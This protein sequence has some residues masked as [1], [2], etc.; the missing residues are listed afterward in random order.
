MPPLIGEVA[1]T[2][3]LT[4]GFCALQSIRRKA[5]TACKSSPAK[6]DAAGAEAVVFVSPFVRTAVLPAARH[7]KIHCGL[8]LSCVTSRYRKL[9]GASITKQIRCNETPIAP[10][11]SECWAFRFFV[12]QMQIL[13]SAF[14]PFASAL[15]VRY[16]SERRDNPLSLAFGEPAPL[17]GEPRGFAEY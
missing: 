1:K 8:L 6:Y 2:K 15:T 9:T 17:F 7:W 4:E 12:S 5:D 11:R 10:M 14:M 16:G 13:T 3:F